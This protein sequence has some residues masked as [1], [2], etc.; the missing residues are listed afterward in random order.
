MGLLAKSRNAVFLRQ[1]RHTANITVLAE[2]FRLILIDVCKH[3]VRL[4]EAVK[5]SNGSIIRADLSVGDSGEGVIGEGSGA[6]V[7]IRRD[8]SVSDDNEENLFGTF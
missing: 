1:N 2:D 4:G 6:G 5:A 7:G 3:Q 8:R